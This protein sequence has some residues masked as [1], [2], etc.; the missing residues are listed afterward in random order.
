VYAQADDG[1][2]VRRL[3][4]V[5]AFAALLVNLRLGNDVRQVCGWLAAQHEH[6]ANN[7]RS[8]LTTSCTTDVQ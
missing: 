8:I 2:N 6:G 5:E 3:V 7:I 1:S 4:A